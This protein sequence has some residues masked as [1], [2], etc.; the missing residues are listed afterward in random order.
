MVKVVFCQ[1]ALNRLRSR[2][3]D[4]SGIKSAVRS[5]QSI[6]FQVNTK[7]RIYKYNNYSVVVKE[8]DNMAIVVTCWKTSFKENKDVIE[9]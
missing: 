1:H 3:M 6:G 9:S 8:K 4:R 2:K 7:N 5:G